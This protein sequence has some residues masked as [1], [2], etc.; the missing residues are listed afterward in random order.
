MGVM[1]HEGVGDSE[2][3]LEDRNKELDCVKGSA[4]ELTLL[5]ALD[6]ESDASVVDGDPPHTRDTVMSVD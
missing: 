6:A 4:R 1:G 2:F 5:S 3:V